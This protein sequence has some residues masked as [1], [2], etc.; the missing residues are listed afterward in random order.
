MRALEAE[1]F[2]RHRSRMACWHHDRLDEALR[3]IALMQREIE[4]L[5]QELAGRP[6]SVHVTA[7]QEGNTMS[8]FA[9][10]APITFTAVTDNAEGAPVADT[11]TWTTT[12]GTIVPGPDSTTI[13]ISDAPL[14]DVTA[15]A[16]DP[17][18]LSG[19]ATAT[20][21]DQ[22]PASVTVTAS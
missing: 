22:T 5:Q 12:A 19:S 16:T 21:A 3:D 4:Q 17:S 15:T 20:V 10:G 14:G 2:A 11:Y 7:S 9:P 13:T 18:G 6:A 1:W 8:S